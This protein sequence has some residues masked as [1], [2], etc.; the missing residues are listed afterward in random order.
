MTLRKK[1]NKATL[2]EALKEVSVSFK[3]EI[4]GYLIG[5]LAMIYHGAKNATKDIDIVFQDEI[6]A[7]AF[8]DN[9]LQLGY[10]E[11]DLKSEEYERLKTF[12]IIEKP[13]GFRFDV[14]IRSV[15]DGLILSDGMKERAEDINLPGNFK[16]SI[17][18]IEDIFLFKSVTDRDDDLADM[19]VLTRSKLD[20][21][22]IRNELIEQPNQWRWYTIF[23][24]NLIALEEDYSISSPL[25]D[26]FG[27]KAEISIAM[28]LLISKLENQPLTRNELVMSIDKTDISFS[29]KVIESLIEQ[30][31]IEEKE[32]FFNLKTATPHE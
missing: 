2:S 1:Y 16:L 6:Q 31:V 9:M 4:N 15:C 21:E 8:K 18:S 5:G 3:E 32:G 12:T 27:E 28:G 7:K 20:W 26:E 19:E 14:F 17:V 29:N 13:N 30:N 11:I 22:I 10:D 23:Y 24:Q 25:K